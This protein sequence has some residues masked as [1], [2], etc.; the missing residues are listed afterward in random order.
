M[1]LAPEGKIKQITGYSMHQAVSDFRR[2]VLAFVVITWFFG[3]LGT[4]TL[5]SRREKITLKGGRN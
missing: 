5:G 1:F 3:K 4:L 2:T